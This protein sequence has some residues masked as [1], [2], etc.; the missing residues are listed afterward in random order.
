MRR[1]ISFAGI[2]AVLPLATYL[3]AQDELAQGKI[4][5]ADKRLKDPNF[6][7]TVVYLI[8]YDEKGAVGLV[9]NRETDMPVSRILR[10]VKEAADRKD[11]VFSGGPVEASSVL[12][13]YRTTT[14]RKGT[15]Q[16]SSNV[17]AVLDET[18]LKEALAAGAAANVLRLY[19]GY[20]GWGPGQLET[21]VGAGAWSV[22][23]GDAKTVFDSDPDTLWG[24]LNKRREPQVVRLPPGVGQ[25]DN[26]RPIANRPLAR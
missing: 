23:S 20:A 26:L 11:F 16:V 2:L 3:Q 1:W 17:F 7:Q 18:V 9:L 5:L 25:V 19:M 22:L 14:K 12:A 10:G 21:E 6:D 4:L 15:R 8:T 24:R 13:L